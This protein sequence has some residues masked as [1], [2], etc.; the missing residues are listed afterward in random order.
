MGSRY[1]RNTRR[2]TPM[3][4][5]PEVLAGTS[6]ETGEVAD[7]ELGAEGEGVGSGPDSGDDSD[8]GDFDLAQVLALLLR[9][10]KWCNC[11]ARCRC[12]S[13]GQVR[14]IQ[15]RGSGI[16][17]LRSSDSDEDDPTSHSEA[18]CPEGDSQPDTK[19]LDDSD[20]K[21]EVLLA[22]ARAQ[23]FSQ[24]Q[25]CITRMLKQREV[26]LPKRCDGFTSGQCS[27]IGSS[28]V[29][30]SMQTM[31][32]YRHKAFCGQYSLDGSVFLSA[33][34]DQNIRLYNV[35]NGK[36]QEFRT[37]R[38]RDVGWSVLDTAFS[39]DGCY[40]IYSSWSDAIHLC[41]IYGDYETHIALDLNPSE[42]RFCIFSLTFSSDNKE[43]LGGA[44]DGCLYIYDRERNERTLRIESH[45]DDVN[46]V[47]YADDSSQI[48]YSGGDD[49]LCR[50]WDRRMLSEN[51]PNAVG[52][53]AGHSDGI[54]FI[55][56]KADARHLISNS[57]DQTI[58][59]WDVRK[60]S[61]PAGLEASRRAVANQNWDYRW[62]PVPKRVRSSSARLAGDT[63]L[64]TYRGHGVLHTL[65]RCRF[66][67]VH[68]TGQRFIYS[69]CSTG[70]VVVYDVLT[71]KI[72]E[73]LRGHKA[74]V[75][76]VSW[77]PYEPKIMSTG[78]D[79]IVGLWERRSDDYQ[80]SDCDSDVFVGWC[81][82]A[83][84]VETQDP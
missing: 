12:V 10:C 67:P 1:S 73:K 74:C 75:R 39:P 56:S 16:A 57:K 65:V 45:E 37:I 26:G 83:L 80:D 24:P 69:G 17:L 53:L 63:S 44:N 8:S 11:L 62:Q 46:A 81:T 76:D 2:P 13:S 18:C 9:R 47:A 36:F 52:T 78:W 42:R 61:P 82:R 3:E 79:G 30:N 54:T 38:A 60:F 23:T 4:E 27:W 34:Q 64:M 49:G 33:C 72:V 71:G 28:F 59:L 7:G 32:Q 70:S 35:A 50:V 31:A 43:V 66:S 6:S 29:P 84:G 5:D 15:T 58:K 51:N 41:N 68:T 77:H 19:T 55:D 22:T 21:Q 20:F 48:L 40:L 25:A 14:L